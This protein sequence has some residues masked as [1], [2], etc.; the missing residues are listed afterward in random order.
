MPELHNEV[1]ETYDGIYKNNNEKGWFYPGMNCKN[2]KTYCYRRVN[3]RNEEAFNKE[4][5]ASL[6]Q[7]KHLEVVAPVRFQAQKIT[8]KNNIEVLTLSH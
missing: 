1:L 3:C 4:K 2:E 7:I 8:C 5:L 6:V